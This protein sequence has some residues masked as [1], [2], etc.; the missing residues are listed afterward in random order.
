MVPAAGP[1][2]P[3][4][5]WRSTRRPEAIEIAR[6]RVPSAR[7][8]VGDLFEWEPSERYDVVFFSFWLSHVP[9]PRFEWFWGLVDSALAPKGRVFF[10]DN[11]RK[12]LPDLAEATNVRS[13]LQRAG[14]RE[15]EV[16][17]RLNDGREFRAVKIYYEPDELTQRLANLGWVANVSATDWFLYYGRATRG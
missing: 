14:E 15:G 9:A 2:R 3:R 13:F 4:R 16:V 1:L 11:Y 17:R 7:Y 8:V 5:S 10:I 12:K 6:R